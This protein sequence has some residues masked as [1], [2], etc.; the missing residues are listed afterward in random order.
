M[1]TYIYI[2][3]YIHLLIYKYQKMDIANLR[4][5]NLAIASQR[6]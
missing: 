1:Y 6:F 2:D 3:T 4:N 5:V